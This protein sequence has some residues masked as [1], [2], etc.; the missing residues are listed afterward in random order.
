MA[1]LPEGVTQWEGPGLDAWR[2]WSPAEAAGRLRGCDASWCVVGGWAIDLFLG[3]Q[4]RPHEDLEIG[5]PRPDF[6]AVR[7]ALEAFEFFVVGDGVVRALS[8]DATPPADKHQNWVLDVSAQA[9]RMDVMLEPG[10]LQTWVFR[11][12][13]A[14]SAPRDAMIDH[15][16][17]AVPYLAPQG[18]LLYKAKATRP[19]D[20]AD[21]A[22]CLP[23]L[24]STAR[25]WLRDALERAH[26]DHPWIERLR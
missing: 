15:G 19:K 26:P 5:V 12:D 14:I 24:T 18:V 16:A 21:F 11:R 25:G 17:D 20:E 1:D 8:A 23:R 2:P 7:G 4:T 3:E 10:D 22:N 13:P 6:G 9:W